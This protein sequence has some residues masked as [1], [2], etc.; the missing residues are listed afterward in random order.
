MGGAEQD[1]AARGNHIAAERRRLGGV[2]PLRPAHLAPHRL[3]LQARVQGD[4]VQAGGQADHVGLH[5]RLPAVA[6]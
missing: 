1:A 5:Q 4:T 2:D 3:H 6:Q